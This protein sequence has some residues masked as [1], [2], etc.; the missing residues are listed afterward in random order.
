[1]FLLTDHSLFFCVLASLESVKS[2]FGYYGWNK[3]KILL[4]LNDLWRLCFDCK[5]II[6]I[7][8]D[9]LIEWRLRMCRYGCLLWYKSIGKI[10]MTTLNNNVMRWNSI[11]F[12]SCWQ[13]DLFD[14]FYR[15]TFD[16]EWNFFRSL[17]KFCL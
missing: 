10:D 5:K 11:W 6:F 3:K 15:Q 7:M 16:V 14:F 1:M 4:Q 17:W 2:I 13:L 8:I 9:K 12:T